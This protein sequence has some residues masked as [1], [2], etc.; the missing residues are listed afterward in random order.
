MEHKDPVLRTWKGLN[1]HLQNNLLCNEKE[2]DRLIKLEQKGPRKSK[3]IMLRIHA[4]LNY[5]RAHRERE[6]I[7]AL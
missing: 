7:R 6:E 3:V 1:E 2:C 5:L 4:R